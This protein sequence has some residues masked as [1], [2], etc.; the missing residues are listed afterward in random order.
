LGTQAPLISFLLVTRNE[1]QHIVPCLTAMLD[2]TLD[3][4]RYEI[5]VVDSLRTDGTREL[6][7]DIIAARP[8]REIR[9][10]DN[11]RRILSSGWNIGIRAARG[12]YVIRPDAHAE[13]PRDFL[14]RNLT[15]KADHSEAAVVGGVLETVGSGLWAETIAA[16]RSSRLGAGNARFRVGGEPGPVRAVVYGLYE[17]RVLLEVGGFDEGLPA[18]QDNVCHARLRAAHKIL[19]FDPRI[20]SRYHP[21]TTLAALWKQMYRRSKWLVLMLKHHAKGGLA[22]RYLVPLLALLLA[23]LLLIAGWHVPLL[24]VKLGVLVGLYFLLGLVTAVRAKLRPAQVLAFPLAMLVL[25]ASYA[26]GTTIG[27]LKYPF[28]RP[29]PSRMFP[30]K[31]LSATAERQPAPPPVS[32]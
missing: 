29:D 1:R 21:R 12:Q 11:P 9:F 25:H 7:Q 30:L 4:T 26:L 23:C 16:L 17:R 22:P 27:C 3:P 32:S 15:A 31:E 10:L 6:I 20:R 5:I 8:D 19:Y 13:V 28:Y 2:Q 18:N 24:W 14:E